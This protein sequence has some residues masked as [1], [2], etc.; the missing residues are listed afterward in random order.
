MGG[1]Y[2]NPVFTSPSAHKYDQVNYHH[3]DPHLGP[4]PGK[5]KILIANEDIKEP[6]TW[7]WTDADLLL[8]E[9]I[10][11]V[12]KRGMY[13]ILDAVFNHMSPL[14]IPFSDV[15]KISKILSSETGLKLRHGIILKPGKNS[16]TNAGEVSQIWQN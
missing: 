5:D 10:K 4:N 13:I 14:S 16:V 11:Q 2:L 12:H 8:L 9:L 15:Q 1:I 3:V 6:S 7:I